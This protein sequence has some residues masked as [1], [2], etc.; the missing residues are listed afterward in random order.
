[1]F[2]TL[3]SPDLSAYYVCLWMSWIAL[4]FLLFQ[5]RLFSCCRVNVFT[6]DLNSISWSSLF[7]HLA[8]SSVTTLGVFWVFETTVVSLFEFHVLAFVFVVLP[9]SFCAIDSLITDHVL[10][11]NWG[12]CWTVHFRSLINVTVLLFVYIICRVWVDAHVWRR[13][14]KIT[15]GPSFLGVSD[16]PLSFSI[17]FFCSLGTIIYHMSTIS[18]HVAVCGTSINMSLSCSMS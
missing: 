16:W 15:A 11:R 12:I 13:R 8:A 5:L 18:V 14:I 1:M 17:I 9:V 2:P 4:I 10:R 6:L 3:V 7:V